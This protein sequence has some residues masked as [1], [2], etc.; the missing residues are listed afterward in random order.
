VQDG[1]QEAVCA[2]PPKKASDAGWGKV[3]GKRVFNVP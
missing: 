3:E 2:N 1:A